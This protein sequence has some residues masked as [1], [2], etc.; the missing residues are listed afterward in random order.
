MLSDD[1][2]DDDMTTMSDDIE[3]NDDD[4]DDDDDGGDDGNADGDEWWRRMDDNDVTQKDPRR[5]PRIAMECV[6][7]R[8]NVW[9][10][11]TRMRCEECGTPMF[12][13]RFARARHDATISISFVA[14]IKMA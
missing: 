2:D 11:Y 4:D 1:D 9:P 7:S 5:G 14:T 6:E 8:L 3:G 13:K 10:N 12:S